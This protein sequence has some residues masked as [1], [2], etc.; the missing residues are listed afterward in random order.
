MRAA[1]LI[2]LSICTLGIILP[3]ASY[4][5]DA[6]VGAVSDPME[7]LNRGVFKVND[8]LDRAILEPVARGYRTMTPEGVRL[9][10]RN[11]LRN[12]RSPINFANQVLQGDLTGAGEQLLRTTVNTVFGIG[13]FDVADSMGLAYEQEDFGQ[14][15]ATWG[16]GDGPYIVA[17]ILGPSNARDLVGVAVDTYADPIRLWLENTDRSH[18]YYTR[19]AANTIDAREELLDVVSDLR[20]NSI[21][22]YAAVRS[23]YSQRRE[24]MIRDDGY[25]SSSAPDIP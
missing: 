11:F 7:G 16:I 6:D 1:L 10:V 2:A 17:P 13:L 23:A 20:K 9:G 21:D 12:L 5:Q 18:W 24:A 3:N 19:V 8:A 14:T 22:Y 15:L 4:A 25:D